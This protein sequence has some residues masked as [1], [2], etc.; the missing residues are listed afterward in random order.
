MNIWNSRNKNIP[1]KTVDELFII[2]SIIEKETSKNSE[3]QLIAGVFYNRI[4]SNM[5][6]QSDPTVIYSISKGKQFDRALTRKD[7]KFKSDY[8]TYYVKGLPP[9]QYVF[10]VYL[11]YMLLLIQKKIITI[12]LLLIEKVVIFFLR[13]M[14]L[15][16]KK[17]N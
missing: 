10:R 6:L 5:K 12:T 14:S 17:L 11:H 7:T 9:L 13:I 2:A 8:N 1:L 4:R 15:I 16:E 3:K